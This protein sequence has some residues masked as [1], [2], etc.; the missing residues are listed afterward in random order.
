MAEYIYTSTVK[1]VHLK[2]KKANITQP[3]SIP[4]GKITK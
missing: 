1:A 3:I 4:I 2:C